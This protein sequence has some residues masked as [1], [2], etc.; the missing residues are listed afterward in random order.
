MKQKYVALVAV[1]IATMFIMIAYSSANTNYINNI[2][3]AKSNNNYVKLGNITFMNNFIDSNN[4]T[5][6]PANI[7]KTSINNIYNYNNNDIKN[8]SITAYQYNYTKSNNSNYLLQY[9]NNSTIKYTIAFT[10]K[11]KDYKVEIADIIANENNNKISYIYANIVPINSS[12]ILLGNEFTLNYKGTYS[13]EMKSLIGDVKL[14]A[15]NYMFSGNS[16]LNKF[17]I[18]YSY[19]AIAMNT[20]LGFTNNNV[21]N[22]VVDKTSAIA[23]DWSWGCIVSITILVVEL[24]GVVA[25]LGGLALSTGITGGAAIALF[26]LGLSLSIGLIGYQTYLIG[27]ACYG[28]W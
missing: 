2:N 17:G 24:M 15:F 8:N 11:F 28:G 26:I 25:M 4:G 27:N 21:K 13:N 23:I 22:I 10:E 1:L 19:I 18:E 20:M 9:Y 12:K 16:T 5:I 3:D 14:V 6:I 7:N